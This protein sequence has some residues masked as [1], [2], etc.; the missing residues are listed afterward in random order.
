MVMS[1]DETSLD[2]A[3]RHNEVAKALTGESVSI[4]NQSFAL[5][6]IIFPTEE[7]ADRTALYAKWPEGG[8][9]LARADGSLIIPTGTTLDLGTFF[10]AFSRRKWCALT[11]LKHLAFRLSGSGRGRVRMLAVMKTTAAS[12][13]LDR[14]V[15]LSAGP[16][17]LELPDPD[18]IPGELVT[19]EIVA[20]EGEVRLTSAAWTTRDAPLREVR[21]AAVITTFRREKAVAASIERFVTTTMPAVPEPG[22]H[23][24][25]IDNGQS[26]ALPP[27]PRVSIIPN[28][29][30]GGA[31]GF[32]RGL[33]EVMDSGRF[34]HCLF[35]DDDASCEPGSIWR[36]MALLARMQ[37]P[38]AGVSGA[39]VLE[40]RP[41]FQWEKGAILL[42]DANLTWPW[43]SLGHARDLSDLAVVATNDGP[44]PEIYGAWWFFAFPLAAVRSLPF[45]FFVRGDDV[46][47]SQSN[48]FPIVTLNGVGSWCES[49]GSKL[50]PP[51]EYLAARSWIALQLMYAHIEGVRV[52]LRCM[53]KLAFSLAMR[54]DYAGME[55][56]LDG[57]ELALRGPAAFG[58]EP[59]PFADIKRIK[60]RIVSAPVVEGMLKDVTHLQTPKSRLQSLILRAANR[61][62]IGGHLLPERLLTPT[63]RHA[64]TGWEAYSGALLR[65]KT[66]ATGTG[67]NLMGYQRDRG[68][69][70]SG[71]RR[72]IR[73]Y[74]FPRSKLAKVQTQYSTDADQFRSRQYWNTQLG[75]KPKMSPVHPAEATK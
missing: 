14:T 64:R 9:R 63:L 67:T 53:V 58:E 26:L 25:V 28:V 54:F 55:A 19:A 35:M 23:L 24:F 57:I 13:I 66:F 32:T 41:Y 46:D 68:R 69:M 6:Q 5:Q 75:L 40:E 43:V 16:V 39:M 34:T 71:I 37:N 17:E 44:D 47:F 73:L 7:R 74:W 2:N 61:I 22:L 30:L 62:S 60:D 59:A 65:A 70:L 3:M 12:V 48:Q 51:T 49:F 11:E 18:K 36:T 27:R 38:R 31:G 56:V 10:N 21:L 42:R 52:S 45:P 20:H 4:T 29:N 33:I 1:A 50:N 8:V 72:I 15:D